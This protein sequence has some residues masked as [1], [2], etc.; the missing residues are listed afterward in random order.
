MRGLWVPDGVTTTCSV[1][2]WVTLL[3]LAP[4]IRSNGP[5]RAVLT[6]QPPWIN[7][8]EEDSVTLTC[9]VFQTPGNH[10]FKWLHNGSP[11][12]IHQDSYTIPAVHMENRGE[13]QCGTEHTALSNSVKLQVYL[14]WLLLQVER[15]KY[16]EGDTMILRCHSWKNNTLRK[17]TYYHNDNALKFHNEIF[18]YIV[19]PVN[20]THSGSYFCKGNIGNTTYLSAPVVITIQGSVEKLSTWMVVI[21]VFVLVV[22]IAVI[23]AATATLCYCK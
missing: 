19:S 6:L 11:L 5:P 8:L 17:V 16:M 14:D 9:E 22:A 15:L 21:I 4:V 23:A 3:C 1:L 13:Y 10:S 20:H 18:D 2:L 12:S 7:V